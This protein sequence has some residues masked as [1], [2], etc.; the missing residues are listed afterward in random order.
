MGMNGFASPRCMRS[1]LTM[2]AVAKQ[3]RGLGPLLD[4]LEKRVK[5][6]THTE[7]TIKA[8]VS[9]PKWQEANKAFAAFHLAP[10]YLLRKAASL[11]GEETAAKPCDNPRDDYS[12]TLLFDDVRL[13]ARE[14][15]DT[16]E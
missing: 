1:S 9:A 5:E 16:I 11:Q 13:N 2:L 7:T 3:L 4:D 6:L 14:I 15:A 12:A 10:H 8:K